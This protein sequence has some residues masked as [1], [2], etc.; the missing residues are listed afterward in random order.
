MQ[1][2]ITAPKVFLLAALALGA[3]P[4]AADIESQPV[5]AVSAQ[6]NHTGP[7]LIV[8]VTMHA[9]VPL[10]IVWEV[11]TDFEHMTQF[12]PN[13]E[14][15]EVTRRDERSVTVK[16]RG[17]ASYAGLSFGYD[18]EREILLEPQT[19]INSRTLSGN[20][21]GARSQSQLTALPGEVLVTYHAESEPK[22]W[23][24]PI[25]GPAAVRNQ[26]ELQF[27]A[28]LSEMERRHAAQG[29]TQK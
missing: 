5:P 13:L 26:T 20:L 21:A 8:D 7:L 19:R 4:A 24:P 2:Q 23:L 3:A 15:S 22:T 16:Q 10:A 12:I 27:R 1:K 25:I 28:M 9:R 6:V 11:L 14:H 29:A 18:S 17:R